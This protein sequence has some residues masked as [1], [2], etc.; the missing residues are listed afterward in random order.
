M[1]QEAMER[2][3]S[4]KEVI[5]YVDGTRVIP[6]DRYPKFSRLGRTLLG[7]EL[8]AE[9]HSRRQENMSRPHYLQRLAGDKRRYELCTCPVAR[10]RGIEGILRSSFRFERS[11]PSNFLLAFVILTP[12][13]CHCTGLLAL[14]G[15][16]I[17]QPT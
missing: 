8:R 13:F 14:T 7:L 9:S 16:C 11:C 1:T 2:E 5:E 6:S 17:F 10:G 4:L 12:L 3:M 15:A